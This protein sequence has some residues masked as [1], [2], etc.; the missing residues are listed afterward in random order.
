MNI[1][2]DPAIGEK[3]AALIPRFSLIVPTL[4]RTEELAKLLASIHKQNRDDVE[5]ILVDQNDDRRIASLLEALPFQL[6]LRHLRQRQKNPSSAR[7]SGLEAATGQIIAFPDDD[8]WYP[9]GLLNEIDS[10]FTSNPEYAVLAVG[11][12]DDEGI[13]SGNR[14]IQNVCD[15]TPFN[16]LRTTFC[17]SLFTSAAKLRPGIRFDP[18]LIGGE[19]TDFVLLQLGTGLR[20]RFDR[21]LHVYHPRRDM[22]SGTVSSARAVRYGAAMGHLVRRHSLHMLWLGLLGYDLSR[23]VMVSLLGRFRDALFCFAHLRGLFTGF[24]LP[25]PES[26]YD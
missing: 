18:G 16:S 3:G 23:A 19:E 4:G 20:G 26:P 7:N 17:S 24:L 22:L 9:T 5:V 12:L 21:R 2:H 13:P 10:W 11:A 25:L 6:N 14:W 8:C 15:I 1:V